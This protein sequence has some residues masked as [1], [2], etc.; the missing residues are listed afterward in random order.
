MPNVVNSTL[1]DGEELVDENDEKTVAYDL[2]SSNHKLDITTKS[3]GSD[4]SGVEHLGPKWK[5]KIEDFLDNKKKEKS[6][7]SENEIE[8]E[9]TAKQ[10]NQIDIESK[11]ENPK[12]DTI[13][14]QTSF[15]ETAHNSF[16][17]IQNVN[18][19][20]KLAITND[21]SDNTNKAPELKLS[22]RSIS[23]SKYEMDF[24]E[25]VMPPK[26]QEKADISG[27]EH[28]GPKWKI[29]IEDFLDN[30][31][32]EKS[33]KSEN[34]IELENTAKQMNQI[35][36]ESKPE[37]PKGDTITEQTSFTETAHNSFASIQNVNEIT[38]LAITNDLSDNTNKAPELKLSPRSISSYKY[39]MDFS[40]VVMPPKVQEKADVF[41]PEDSW[42]RVAIPFLPLGVA[43]VCLLMNI[44]LPGSGTILSGICI[45][46]CATPRI[47]SKY[48][49]DSA[50]VCC[51][52][53]LVGM[54]QFFT[55][56]FLLVGWFWGVSWGIKMIHL[57]LQRRREL[58]D[59][60]AIE[61]KTMAI[62]AFKT[63]TLE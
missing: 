40:E 27:V 50:A 3:G 11:P 13:T 32:K 37:N 56:T 52:N 19:T 29:K 25:V 21:L 8:L 49:Q 7:K 63:S 31:K 15:T 24:S 54:A 48:D 28:L 55:T 41:T 46:C 23:S 39:E 53:V 2:E 60:R 34:E 62:K 33:F 44:V 6:F 20:I 51:V 4:I 10:M 30:K 61:L 22:P 43:V 17:S 38:K 36:I 14:E 58:A 57:S 45:F 16:A 47:P 26:V 9:N 42:I 35:D 18:E 59:Q 1:Q 5:I 12:G